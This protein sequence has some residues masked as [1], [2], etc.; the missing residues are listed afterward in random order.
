[1]FQQRTDCGLAAVALLTWSV[2]ACA[3]AD[4][5]GSGGGGGSSSA[6]VGGPQTTTAS[7]GG[8]NATTTG[9][10]STS[11]ATS[12]GGAGSSSSQSTGTSGACPDVPFFGDAQCDGC[13]NASCCAEREVCEA[14]P[15][16]CFGANGTIAYETPAGAAL[17]DCLDANCTSECSGNGCSPG[18]SYGDPQVDACLISQCC[19]ELEACTDD[20]ANVQA[21]IDCLDA[22]GTGELCAAA[23]ACIEENGCLDAATTICDTGLGTGDAA[24]DACLGDACCAEFEAC[25][26]EGVPA[27][28]DCFDA[29]G[30]GP[31]CA[32]ALACADQS[33]C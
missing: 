19:A 28:L 26:A 3:D 10:T 15:T 18:I 29:G 7:G 12:T 17:I 1:M 25:V 33:G 23:S 9:A 13:L 27:C 8:G 5:D 30:D 22:G 31:L 21:C 20:G 14:S 24:M 2:V 16:E 11:D 32:D 4:R 6:Q